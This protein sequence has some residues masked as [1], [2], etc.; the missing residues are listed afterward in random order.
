[1]KSKKQTD[2]PQLQKA[3]NKWNAAR[4]LIA[5]KL[6]CLGQLNS[7][8]TEAIAK[9]KKEYRV[10]QQEVGNQIEK[11]V[12]E[13]CKEMAVFVERFLKLLKKN[14]IEMQ[15]EEVKQVSEEWD[16]YEDE[17]R[18]IEDEYCAT[19]HYKSLNKGN[20]A[21]LFNIFALQIQNNYLREYPEET[22]Y[23]PP[24]FIC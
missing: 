3:R 24:P 19:P 5:E 20:V 13:I 11:D 10:K 9:I 21:F 17:L 1:M 12:R 16:Q 15:L 6:E 8:Q 4:Q 22:P 18:N 23:K 2:S 14:K 7:E